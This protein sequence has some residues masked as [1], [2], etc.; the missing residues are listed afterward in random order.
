MKTIIIIAFICLLVGVFIL[1]GCGKFGKRG[2]GNVT[3]ENRT[4]SPFNAVNISG[5]F[6][7]ELSQDGG[8]EWVKVEAD[9][10]L[11]KLITVTSAGGA[12]HVAMED[13]AS[14]RKSTRFKVYINIK[15]IHQLDVSSVGTLT[16]ANTL[17]LDSIEV[18]GESVGKTN[19]DIDAAFLRA[20]LKSI[21]NTMLTGNVAE[22][23]I[24]NKSVGSLKAYGL[25]TH[26][27]MIH[28]TAVGS[29]EI[30]AD[31]AFYI[32][33]S[34]IGTLH[35]KGPGVVKELNSEGIGKVQKVEG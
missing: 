27:M 23:R 34:A 8:A 10:N 19:L 32:R 12:L 14:I 15:N 30:Y 18:N 3:T 26:T 33:S 6:P 16:C 25:K 20:N 17:K 31:S 2:S 9:D 1:T 7:V 11:Q 5:I 24:N 28:N 4:V 29:A 22:A 35:Y 13:K 21:G